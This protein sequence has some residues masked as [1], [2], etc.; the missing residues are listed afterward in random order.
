MPWK[1]LNPKGRKLG[2]LVSFSA[3]GL[4]SEGK[5]FRRAADVGSRLGSKVRRKSQLLSSTRRAQGYPATSS[6]NPFIFHSSKRW[7]CRPCGRWRLGTRQSSW[8]GGGWGQHVLSFRSVV[9]TA[10][11]TFYAWDRTRILSTKH[12]KEG[13]TVTVSPL[14]SG[15]TG[16]YRGSLVCLRR[17]KCP[18]AI[19]CESQ[20]RILS[21]QWCLPF[22]GRSFLWQLTRPRALRW[23]RGAGGGAVSVAPRLRAGTV[24]VEWAGAREKHRSQGPTAELSAKLGAACFWKVV[25]S[26]ERPCNGMD[27]FA[28]KASKVHRR[29]RMLLFRFH[30]SRCRPKS[31]LWRQQGEACCVMD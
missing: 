7:A 19:A 8:W 2:T 30:R 21:E 11:S 6:T 24:W 14:T 17:S 27:D 9:V 1:D 5:A 28:A 12:S 13:G 25:K 23:E 4:K 29:W 16:T 15:D 10:R 20:F 22:R 26:T 31:G 3:N 18:L